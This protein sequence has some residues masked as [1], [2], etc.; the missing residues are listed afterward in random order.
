MITTVLQLN[1]KYDVSDE[2]YISAV[3]PL[4][5]QFADIPGLMWKIWMVNPD[6][7]EAGGIYLFEDA[8]HVQD[9]LESNLAANLTSHPAF[10]EFRIKTFALMP[11]QSVVTRAPI[12]DVAEK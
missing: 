4:A 12:G 7:N 2:D 8:G 1:F 9:F 11:D 3:V 6:E 5:G 10:R